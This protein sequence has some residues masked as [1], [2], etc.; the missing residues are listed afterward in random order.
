MFRLFSFNK[1]I[2]KLNATKK[3]LISFLMQYLMIKNSSIVPFLL[4]QKK[5]RI[6]NQLI[7]RNR[8]R[9]RKRKRKRKKQRNRENCTHNNFFFFFLC[10]I[11]NKSFEYQFSYSIRTDLFFPRLKSHFL[12]LF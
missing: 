5:K 3:F 8:N 11:F 1:S 6:N 10:F 4:N 2:M 9:K 7:D 12:N